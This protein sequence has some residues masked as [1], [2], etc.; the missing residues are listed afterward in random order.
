MLTGRLLR[1][2]GWY[3]VAS[4]VGGLA[5]TVPSHPVASQ[6]PTPR[7]VLMPS[8]VRAAGMNGAGA[9]LVGDAGSVFSNPA[10]LVTVSHLSFEGNYRSASPSGFAA[11]GALAWRLSRFNFGGGLQYFDQGGSGSG[12]S[13]HELVGVGSMVYRF[14]L[15]AL[16]VSARGVERVVGSQTL[17]GVSG[18]IGV[19]LAVF[20]IMALAFAVQNVN[21]NWDENGGLALPRLTRLGFNMNYTDPQEGF[22]LQ[23][24]IEGQWREGSSARVVIGVEAG[25]TVHRVGFQARAG[26]GSRVG[27]GSRIAFGGTVVLSRFSIDYAREAS[28]VAGESRHRLG[29]RVTW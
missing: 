8:S 17:N 2:D 13:D 1:Q 26:Y 23:S 25:M 24:T 22:R 4:L 12:S 20:D 7:P 19:A 14:G 27:N 28:V 18:D 21:G 9:A 29:M 10:G 16:G 3:L 6:S 15:L 5:L 11:A